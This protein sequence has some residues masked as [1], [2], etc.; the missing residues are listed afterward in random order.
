VPRRAAVLLVIVGGAALLVG[1][2]IQGSDGSSPAAPNP[3]IARVVSVVD[4]DTLRLDFVSG[5]QRRVRYAGVDAPAPDAC[6][7]VDALRANR[8]LAPVGTRVFVEYDEAREDASGTLVAYLRRVSDGVFLNAAL[9]RRGAASVYTVP[10]NVRHVDALVAAARD[11][12]EAGRGV[13]ACE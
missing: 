7:G 11:A 12:R 6:G 3:R 4:A 10:P 13:W 5:A 2:L 9:L 1:S 8:S